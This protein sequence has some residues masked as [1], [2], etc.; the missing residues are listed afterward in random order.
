MKLIYIRSYT[1]FVSSIPSTFFFLIFL[2]QNFFIE[3]SE[4]PPTPFAPPY[5][6]NLKTPLKPTEPQS[7]DEPTRQ[8]HLFTG[9]AAK[10][11]PPDGEE[12]AGEQYAHSAPEHPVEKAAQQGG[13]GGC[14]HSTW[15]EHLL[16][17]GAQVQLPL[18]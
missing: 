4:T 15:Y 13:E 12:E 6:K 14:G 9:S 3:I 16:P 11:D 8:E 18:Q 2:I 17:Q 7:N 5:F 10:D 1:D